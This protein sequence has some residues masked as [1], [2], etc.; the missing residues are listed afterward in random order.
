MGEKVFFLK[1]K[2]GAKISARLLKGQVLSQKFCQT[3]KRTVKKLNLS[4]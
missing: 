2:V 3:F 1:D 4:F